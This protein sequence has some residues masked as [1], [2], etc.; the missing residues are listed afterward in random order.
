MRLRI[1]TAHWIFPILFSGPEDAPKI[2]HF[3]WGDLGPHLIMV[4]WAHP[5]PLRKQHLHWFSSF[6]T[7]RGH[8][9]LLLF[10][11]S[12][13]AVTV[14]SSHISASSSSSCISPPSNFVNG[15]VST[16]WFIVCRWPQLQDGDW[17]RQHLFK[18]ARHNLSN[19]RTDHVSHL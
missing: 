11:F 6:K 13:A 7:A 10:L 12:S 9:Q 18:L 5:S 1:S 15:R 16:M 17:V 14:D 8:V 4:P 19:R 3:P 2:A